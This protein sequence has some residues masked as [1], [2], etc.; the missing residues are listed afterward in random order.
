M[1]K[2]AIV[3][4]S[5]NK[6]PGSEDGDGKRTKMITFRKRARKRYVYDYLPRS[7]A[8]RWRTDGGFS[9]FRKRFRGNSV[10]SPGGRQSRPKTEETPAAVTATQHQGTRNRHSIA[11]IP[12]VYK[13]TV[14]AS[15]NRSRKTTDME[16]RRS[17]MKENRGR[18]RFLQTRNRLTR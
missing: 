16:V 6:N 10:P 3:R 4:L 14:S 11:I 12:T 15:T 17:R 5:F 18:F 1:C 8:R 9:I 7:H 2:R 13:S